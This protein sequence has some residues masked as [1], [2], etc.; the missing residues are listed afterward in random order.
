[1][2]SPASVPVSPDTLADFFS[3]RHITAYCVADVAAIGAPAGR[4]PRDLLPCCR[5]IIIFGVVMPD[6]FFSG[7]EREQSEETNAIKHALESTTYALR[8]LLERWGSR[9]VAIVPFHHLVVE[10]GI[11]RGRLSL[12]HCAADAGFGTLG[13]NGLL[14]HPRYGNR[15]A[16]AAVLTDEVIGPFPTSDGTAACTHC[17]RCVTACKAGAIHDGVVTQTLCRNLTDYVPTLF[18]PL[19]WR[20]MRGRY[21]ARLITVLLNTAVSCV[22]IRGTCT[23]CMTACPYFKIP[24]R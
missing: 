8:D 22:E 15:L 14:I 9:S 1:M 17:N 6:R 20:L 2:S 12:K 19:A 3:G 21:S 16:L 18:R 4:H 10:D 11:L 7:T 13:D 23:A 5:T 24:E